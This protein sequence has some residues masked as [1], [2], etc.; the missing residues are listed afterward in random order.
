MHKPESQGSIRGLGMLTGCVTEL[1]MLVG[2]FSP[3][4]YHVEHASELSHQEKGSRSIYPL[5]LSLLS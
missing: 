1:V 3:A 2:N 5:A 4:G